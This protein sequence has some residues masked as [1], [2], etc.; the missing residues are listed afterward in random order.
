[1]TDHK[2]IGACCAHPLYSA[3]DCVDGGDLT[4]AFWATLLR[5]IQRMAAVATR[6]IS[7]RKAG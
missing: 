3:V 1:M 2:P 4:D 6:L 7:S 5:M